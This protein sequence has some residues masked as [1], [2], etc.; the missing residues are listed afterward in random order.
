MFEGALSATGDEE[1]MLG[2][3]L[4]ARDPQVSPN[5]ILPT[6]VAE[7]ATRSIVRTHR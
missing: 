4:G 1:T 7:G 2:R 3:A 5:M 6:V